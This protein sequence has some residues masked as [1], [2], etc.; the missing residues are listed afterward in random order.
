M[1][2]TQLFTKTLKQA[3]AD[4]DS[5]NVELLTRAGFIHKQMAGVYSFLPLGLRV[6]NKIE[7]IV[8]EEMEAIGGQEI[9]MPAL[10][11]EE[12]WEK[13][14][15]ADLDIL[16]HLE[17]PDKAKY[18][19]NPTHEEVLT[20]LAK[21][22]ISSYKDLPIAVF[23]FQAKFRKELR[24]KSG[25]LR[26]RE[27]FM[28]DLYSFHA[29]KDDLAQYYEKVKDAYFRIFKRVGLVKKTILTFAS[30]GSFSKYSHE[31]Q[32][33]CSA[34]EDTIYICKKCNV[35]I[36]EEIIKEQPAHIGDAKSEAGRL[37]C[38]ECSNKNLIAEK[39]AEVGNIFKLGTKFSEVFELTYKDVSGKEHLAEMG[40]YGIGLPRVMGVVVEVF[41]DEKGIIWPKSIA[42]FIA[43]ILT[44]EQDKKVIA[45]AEKIFNLLSKEGI[46]VLYDDR[47]DASAGE[48]FADADLIGIP[49]RLVI[50]QKTLIKNKVELKERTSSKTELLD[51]KSLL[52]KLR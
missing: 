42:P 14:K 4:A 30:G 9:V 16:F 35:A 29:D 11:Q 33:V 41:N 17:G 32:T 1:R 45:F 15:R 47:V 31:F 5:K 38:P 2:F 40:C 50:S 13:T 23:Q 37:V 7:S 8:R 43:H 52:T 27:F 6:L 21:K 34:G 20:P 46:E 24:A 19:L 26:T 28:K 39:A 22:Y 48:K 12:S 49:L 18:V 10:T 36:N 51:L 3:P 25:I 44:V